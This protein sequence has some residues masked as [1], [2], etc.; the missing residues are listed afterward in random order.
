MTAEL[1]SQ[2]NSLYRFFL[3]RVG[4]R[5]VSGDLAQET[6]ARLFAYQKTRTVANPGALCQH[7]AGN[8]LRDHFRAKGRSAEAPLMEDVVCTA[9]HP[10][11]V[12]MH[13]QRIE[14]FERLVSAMP[15]MRREVF[16]RRRL[17][18]ESTRQIAADLGLSEAAVE[19]H[20]VRA[21]EWLHR[22][23]VRHDRARS[24]DGNHPSCGDGGTE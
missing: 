7:I 20:M 17:H 8:L 12:V 22:E 10:D 13:R 1:T 11:E 24:P 18:G 4:D 15:D 6:F 2:W 9:P 3:R 23:I 14:V 19:K 5:D 21:V 16:L